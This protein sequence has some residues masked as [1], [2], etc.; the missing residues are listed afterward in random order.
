[1]MTIEVN[2]HSFDGIN[3]LSPYIW[4]LASHSETLDIS[5][6]SIF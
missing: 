1:M 6:K 2:F 5:A 3:E 4:Y